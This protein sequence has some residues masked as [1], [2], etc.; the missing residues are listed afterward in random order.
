MGFGYFDETYQSQ[1]CNFQ[2]AIVLLNSTY[3]P[4]ISKSVI[5]PNMNYR[6][7]L[8]N[9]VDFSGIHYNI[10]RYFNTLVILLNSVMRKCAGIVQLIKNNR[11]F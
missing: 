1:E 2:L 7:K 5:E 11:F 8:K 4:Y 3:Y 6:N 10:I 9:I